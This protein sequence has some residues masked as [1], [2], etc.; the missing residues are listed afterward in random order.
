[1]PSPEAP[2][3]DALLSIP[4][5]IAELDVPR[6]TFYRWRQLRKGPKAIKLPNGE[7]RIRRSEMDRWVSSMEDAA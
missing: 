7:V 6:S 4:Q 3:G 2:Q 5:V 1:M